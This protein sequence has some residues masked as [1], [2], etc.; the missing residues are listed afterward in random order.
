M[1]LTPAEK[2]A[3]K[4][5]AEDNMIMFHFGWAMNMRNEFGMWEGNNELVESCGASK[6]D[7]ASMAIVKAVWK[8]LN[9]KH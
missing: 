3:L 1:P 8:E 7:G 9:R 4:N 5:T 2:R 6:L